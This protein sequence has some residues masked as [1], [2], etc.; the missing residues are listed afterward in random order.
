VNQVMQRHVIPTGQPWNNGIIVARALQ[1]AGFEAYAAGGC[2]RD[3]LLSVPVQ[4]I[5]LATSATPEQVELVCK[6]NNWQVVTVGKSFGVTVVVLP[7]GKHIEVATFRHDGIYQDGRRPLTVQFSSAREDV[8]RRDFT[9]NA[10]LLDINQGII[11]DYVDGL[12]DLKNK[13]IRAVGDPALRFTEDHLRI[14]R[15]L[16]FAAHYACTIEDKTWDAIKCGTLSGVS[17]ERIVQEWTKTMRHPRR[18]AWFRFLCESGHLDV[19]CPPLAPCP[20]A[21][22]ERLAATLAG[23]GEQRDEAVLFSVWLASCSAAAALA[24]LNSLP[25][26]NALKR[27]VLFILEHARDLDTFRQRSLAERRRCWRHEH[28]KRLVETLQALYGQEVSALCAEAAREPH[29]FTPLLSAEEVLRLGVPQGPYL[30]QLLRHL[31]DAQLEGR[32][33]DR[34]AA[35]HAALAWWTARQ[36]QAEKPTGMR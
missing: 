24:W 35:E 15:G 23:M 9:I 3:L 27:G 4:D 31:E 10:L 36:N 12:A 13:I 5:D 16:R 6:N 20:P 18:S 25:L 22:R 7:D 34:A 33:A 19:V 14:L 29:E 8:L 26:A 28:G 30:G 32:L 17:R 1:Q 11:L 21:Q 2:V